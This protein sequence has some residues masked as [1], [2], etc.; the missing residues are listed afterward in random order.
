MT[1]YYHLI[2][3]NWDSSIE[4]QSKIISEL[5]PTSNDVGP[6]LDCACGIGTQIIGLKKLGYSIEGSDISS[7]EVERAIK[8]AAIRN[9]AIDIRVDDMRTL[10]TARSNHYGAILA[11]DNAIPHLVSDEEILQALLAIKERLKPGGILLISLRDYE[12]I[13]ASQP[14]ITDPVF[15]QDKN[16]RRIVHQVWD[17]KDRRNYAVHLYITR[18]E[19]NGWDVKHFYGQYRAVTTKELASLIDKAGFEKTAILSPAETSFYQPIISSVK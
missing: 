9:L 7:L 11:M 13:I 2:F 14:K 18:Q 5:L 15:F 17:W 19:P 8:E 3:E 10:Q 1:E 6:V 4:N 12:S 16:G